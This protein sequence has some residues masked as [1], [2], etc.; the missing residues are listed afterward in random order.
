MADIQR[1]LS[2][3]GVDASTFAPLATVAE[4]PLYSLTVPGRRAAAVWRQLRDLYGETGYWPVMLGSSQA[5]K[6]WFQPNNNE[7]PIPVA[8][9]ILQGESMDLNAKMEKTLGDLNEEDFED[10]D[11]ELEEFA[12][13]VEGI[14]A[15]ES[16]EDE[17]EDDDE[18]LRDAAE[19]WGLA[20]EERSREYGDEDDVE[21]FES[22]EDDSESAVAPGSSGFSFSIC[23][24][25]LTNRFLAEVIIGLIP[26]EKPWH[27]PAWLGWGGWN[28]CP[29]PAQQVAYMKRWNESHGAEV[30]GMAADIVEM[31]ATRPPQDH[32]AALAL[33]REQFCYCEDIVFQG[34]GSLERLAQELQ[35]NP[36]WYFWW[37]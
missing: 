32:E 34:T 29:G 33:A 37:D 11:E 30:V 2:E 4:R 20:R 5:P 35:G 1:I 25:I 9:D 13:E 26:A 6:G 8:E 18:E 19:A 28:E 14:G 36:I 27:V 31:I 10:F 24:D 3:R 12:D 15:D 23:K 7:Q 22:G 16:A 21:D 17:D